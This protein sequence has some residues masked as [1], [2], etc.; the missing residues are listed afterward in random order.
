M[1]SNFPYYDPDYSINKTYFDPNTYSSVSVPTYK[2]WR[3][4]GVVTEV[5]D[6]VDLYY[7]YIVIGGITCCLTS[8]QDLLVA[9]T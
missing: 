2:D 4:E 6:Q 8:S 3:D 9:R 7:Y 5:K 1:E